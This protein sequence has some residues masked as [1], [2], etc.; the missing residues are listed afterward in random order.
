MK[1]SPF[2]IPATCVPHLYEV[3]PAVVVTTNAGVTVP[4]GGNITIGSL[5][6]SAEDCR[7][8]DKQLVYRITDAPGYGQIELM[9]SPGVAVPL[10]T[11]EDL[12]EDLVLYVHFGNGPAG[13]AF[14]FEV[15][16]VNRHV[17]AKGT[18]EIE[19]APF[20]N[21]LQDER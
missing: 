11:Q 10:F 8:D 18:F 19:V 1:T 21:Y 7:L 2:S 6:L 20:L 5:E 4:E 13:D 3:Q 15:T 9:S 14:E 12:N 16:S 17:A